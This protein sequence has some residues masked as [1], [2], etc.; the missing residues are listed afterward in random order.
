MLVKRIIFFQKIS[1]G[2]VLSFE[3]FFENA[4]VPYTVFFRFRVYLSF[5]SFIR[6]YYE[7]KKTIHAKQ[8]L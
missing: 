7:G 5:Q 6:T 1:L 4:T 8:E 2:R 3:N